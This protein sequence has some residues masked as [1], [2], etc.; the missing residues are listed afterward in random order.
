MQ[1]REALQPLS[2]DEQDDDDQPRGF[3]RLETLLVEQ[4]S[5]D[6]EALQRDPATLQTWTREL[7][8]LMVGNNEGRT[9]TYNPDCPTQVQEPMRQHGS[10]VIGWAGSHG[11]LGFSHQTKPQW[12]PRPGSMLSC[13]ASCV[14]TAGSP[15]SATWCC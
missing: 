6:A 1:F 7:P 13:S 4:L 10:Q 12:F 9:S 2:P 15:T 11:S 5:W 3:R 8:E 14:N